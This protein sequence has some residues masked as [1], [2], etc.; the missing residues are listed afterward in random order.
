MG[1]YFDNKY[2]VYL[3]QFA[4]SSCASSTPQEDWREIKKLILIGIQNEQLVVPYSQEHLLESALRDAERAREQDRFLFNL[5]GGLSLRPEQD[6]T[7]R[8][9]INCARKRTASIGTFCE[10]LPIMGFD[11]QNGFDRFGAV[12]REFNSM[13]GDAV[14][15][16]NYLREATTLTPGPTQQLKDFVLHRKMEYYK[17]EL[18]SRLK[19]FARYGFFD[20]K[21][22]SFSFQSIPLWAD[23]LMILLIRDYRMSPIEARKIKEALEKWGL[24]KAVP[25]LFIRASLEA[26]MALK[27][28]QETPNDA[29]DLQRLGAA[30]PFADI[31]LTDKAKLFDVKLFSLDNIYKADVF[32]GSKS[33]LFRFKEKLKEIVAET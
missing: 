8:L 26:A 2:C 9:L 29:I 21:T 14:K 11:L 6:I 16:V 10:K 17:N 19:K 28:Q 3:D 7:A 24:K 22:V 33:E 23:A 15:P 13:I 31:V 4:V 32:S 30:L 20:R 18:T 5:S 25:T 1:K 12:K 27:H